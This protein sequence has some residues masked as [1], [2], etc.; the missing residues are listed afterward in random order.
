MTR[1]RLSG[2]S[3]YLKDFSAHQPRSGPGSS[4]RT[5]AL[6]RLSNTAILKQKEKA[7]EEDRRQRERE[8]LIIQLY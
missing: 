5:P 1:V 4:S 7:V 6:S 2:S 8:L 3:K